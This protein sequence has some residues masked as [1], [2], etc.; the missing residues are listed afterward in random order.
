MHIKGDITLTK[1]VNKIFVDVR[2]RFLAFKNN[3][4][5]TNCRSRIN[6]VLIDNREDLDIVMPVY[7]SLEYS[8]NH[9]KT[10]GSLRNYYRDEPNDP[11][12]N[13]DDF[14]T[15]N[16]NADPIL[17]VLIFTSTNFREFPEIKHTQNIPCDQ[18]LQF[19]TRKINFKNSKFN[20]IFSSY[21]ERHKRDI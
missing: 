2:N 1:T 6:N 7:N 19:N 14:P 20:Q 5:F 8:K 13:D 12:L 10:T 17:S 11:P 18:I 15:V 16:Y 3:G 4:P 21:L 9:K